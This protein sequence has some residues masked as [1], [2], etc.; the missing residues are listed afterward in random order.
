MDYTHVFPL[1]Q[2]QMI[3]A[4]CDQLRAELTALKSRAASDPH[5]VAAETAATAA[6]AAA[7]AAAVASANKFG[8]LTHLQSLH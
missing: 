7:A 8:A 3:R 5:P 6:A 4:E 1:P 2:Y